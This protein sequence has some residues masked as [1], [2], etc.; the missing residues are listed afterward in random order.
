M[1][2]DGTD[3]QQ[4]QQ[5]QKQHIEHEIFGTR[6]GGV[7]AMMAPNL[8]TPEERARHEIDHMPYAAWCRSC[9]AGKGKADPHFLKTSDDLGVQGVACD[10]CFMGDAVESDKATDKCLPIL[11]HKFYG[12]RWV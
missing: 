3:E 11:V 12:G 1:E 9:V 10:Y 7:P 8:P 2:E 4:E 6:G 5:Q